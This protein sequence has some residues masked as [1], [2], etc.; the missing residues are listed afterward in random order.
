MLVGNVAPPSV[1]RAM[2]TVPVTPD[3][4]HVTVCDEPIGHDSP[5]FGEVTVIVG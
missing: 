5:P 4:V 1:E 2:D 3:D